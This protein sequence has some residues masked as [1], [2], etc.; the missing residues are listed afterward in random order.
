MSVIVNG[1]N[2]K[3]IQFIRGTVKKWIHNGK[4]VYAASSQISTY[5]VETFYGTNINSIQTISS[6]TS[7]G[8]E[9]P[10]FSFSS[11]YRPRFICNMDMEK[12]SYNISGQWRAVD[13]ASTIWLA[14]YK[15]GVKTSVL[16]YDYKGT[17]GTYTFNKSA[18]FSNVKKGDLLEIRVAVSTATGGRVGLWLTFTCKY[19]A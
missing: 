18:T 13:A 6:G 7:K 16:L 1:V 19:D 4:L 8:I 12:V 14:S 3:I 5:A 10:A 15:N 11:G 17:I 9:G 2:L